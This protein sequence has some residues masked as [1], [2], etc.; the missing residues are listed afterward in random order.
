MLSLNVIGE[1]HT[2]REL[3]YTCSDSE[4]SVVVCRPEYRKIV[5]SIANIMVHEMP[6]YNSFISKKQS[7]VLMNTNLDYDDALLLYTSG[8]TGRPKGVLITRENIQAQIES[9]QKAWKWDSHDHIVSIHIVT[10]AAC[11]ATASYSWSYK[12]SFNSC[13]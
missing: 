1:N 2:I 6:S 9:M 7:E 12:L 3:T 10:L 5:D 8:T 4:A 11:F 13:N